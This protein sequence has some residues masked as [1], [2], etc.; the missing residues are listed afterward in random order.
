MKFAY[1]II[2]VCCLVVNAP[3]LAQ[4][5]F[6]ICDNKAKVLL[7]N[8]IAT[9]AA[10]ADA[11]VPFANLTIGQRLRDRGFDVD[12]QVVYNQ[13]DGLSMDFLEAIFV[14]D[15]ALY[16]ASIIGL[17]VGAEVAAAVG[18]IREILS[19]PR[20][21]RTDRRGNINSA[22]E[23]AL[24]GADEI[25]EEL[26]R[27]LSDFMHEEGREILTRTS[28]DT[29]NQLR[30]AARSATLDGFRT[31]IL[32]HSQGGLFANRVQPLFSP[33]A[34]MLALGSPI[35]RVAGDP[36][37]PTDFLNNQGITKDDDIVMSAVRLQDPDVYPASPAYV[38]TEAYQRDREGFSGHSF[39]VAYLIGDNMRFTIE[40][41]A[42]T[43]IEER[44]ESM[45]PVRMT[46]ES[47]ATVSDFNI[48]QV[49]IIT[50]S[51]TELSARNRVVDD[52]IRLLNTIGFG[53]NDSTG[54]ASGP[55]VGMDCDVAQAGQ[56]QVFY[57]TSLDGESSP[58][59]L[60][61]DFGGTG[62]PPDG[63][64]PEGR[65]RNVG[66][67]VRSDGGQSQSVHLGT[68]TVMPGG[69][70]GVQAWVDQD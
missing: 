40:N 43:I 50:P 47:N 69:P 34:Q 7:V 29:T 54:F 64:V 23:Q 4:G 61:V 33:Y 26:A 39:I 66:G 18:K 49:R 30:N 51:G 13:S 2:A 25:T 56:Y 45:F 24:P 67:T 1:T 19:E 8:G 37:E 16:E 59:E 32:A 53:G 14:K 3:A 12:F 68:F 31:L 9:T 42:A 20:P 35:D 36:F 21:P 41:R 38:N 48:A 62:V 70:T 28:T 65:A 52:G 46:I 63:V 6:D 57:D 17:G 60:R 11:V 55:F 10:G 58:Y 22:L 27:S 15:P 44:T 5:D